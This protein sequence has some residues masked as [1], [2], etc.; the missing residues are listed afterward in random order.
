[1]AASHIQILQQRTLFNLELPG[2]KGD[3]SACLA[4]VRQQPYDRYVVFF[5]HRNPGEQRW[6]EGAFTTATAWPQPPQPVNGGIL[7]GG[8]RYIIGFVASNPN[9]AAVCV[10][11]ADGTVVED[12]FSNG[13]VLLVVPLLSPRQREKEAVMQVLDRYDVGI[14]SMRHWVDLRPPPGI[15]PPQI[16]L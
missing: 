11:L 9:V 1:M 14:I 2:G 15:V 5:A 12:K 6:L 7:I 3:E 10:T 8:G 16:K 4:L 13:S